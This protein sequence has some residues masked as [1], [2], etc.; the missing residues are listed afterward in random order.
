MSDLVVEQVAHP[1]GDEGAQEV[2]HPPG[3]VTSVRS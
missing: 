3:N 1:G 2:V